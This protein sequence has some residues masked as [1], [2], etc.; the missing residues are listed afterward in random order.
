MIFFSLIVMIPFVTLVKSLYCYYIGF[1]K[2]QFSCLPFNYL[3]QIFSVNLFFVY[4]TLTYT[5]LTQRYIVIYS[6]V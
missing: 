4:Y 6:S 3:L 1:Y 2:L 5:V